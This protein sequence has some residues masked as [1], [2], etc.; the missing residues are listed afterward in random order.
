MKVL[1]ITGHA[2]SGKDTAA[3]LVQM[4]TANYSMS[5][6]VDVKVFIEEC[7]KVTL[8]ILNTSSSHIER[9]RILKFAYPIY[10]IAA[11]LTGHQTTGEIMTGDFKNKSWVVGTTMYTGRQI[12]Q[13]IGTECFR[14][15]FDDQVWIGLMSQNLNRIPNAVI[16]DLRFLNEATFIEQMKGTIVRIKG[17]DSGV[18]T[19]HQ[20]ESEIDLIKPHYTIHN[21]GDYMFLAYQLEHMCRSLNILNCQYEWKTP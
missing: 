17:R 3:Y 7:Q 19:T 12:L 6:P 8:S 13:K 5:T 16:S 15:V 4:M 2:G 10:Q 9:F 14:N 11:I 1:A 20:S 21:T 18:G